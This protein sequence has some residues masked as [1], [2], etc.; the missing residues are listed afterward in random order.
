MSA[1]D[2]LSGLIPGL[3]GGRHAE[4]TQ[5]LIHKLEHFGT[6]TA[7][8]RDILTSLCAETFPVGSRTEVARDGERPTGIFVLLDG[9]ACRFK[10][11]ANGAR[12]ILAYM[13]PGD[14][15]DLD[16]ALLDR[17]DHAI[18]SLSPCR[19]ARIAFDPLQD[20]AQDRNHLIALMRRANLMDDAILRE[21]L[22]NLGSRSA[23]ERIAHLLLELLTRL[24]TVGLARSD[25]YDLPTSQ[26]DLADTT[27]LSTVHVNRTL[28]D[29]KRQGLIELRSRVLTIRNIPCL[30]SLSGF[31][32]AYLAPAQNGGR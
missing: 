6:L 5:P 14:F 19:F 26:I 28:Q 31:D 7:E 9:M 18:A 22:V 21:W 13:V 20:L 27:G 8:D 4:A 1:P 11:R 30:T 3:P 24:R 10:L 23:I 16:I 25:G 2:D 32:P 15:C 17:R 12:Q 29:L